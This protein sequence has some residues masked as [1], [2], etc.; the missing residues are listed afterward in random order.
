VTFSLSA[1]CKGIE[2]LHTAEYTASRTLTLSLEIISEVLEVLLYLT[3][4]DFMRKKFL[5]LLMYFRLLNFSLNAGLVRKTPVN[6]TGTVRNSVLCR[7]QFWR[8]QF[9]GR[10]ATFRAWLVT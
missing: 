7:Q 5:K 8:S 4:I 9:V 1:G 2:T 3:I 10:M 6:A